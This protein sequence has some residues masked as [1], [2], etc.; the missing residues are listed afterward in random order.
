[1]ERNLLELR[2]I[3]KVFPGVKALDRVNLDLKSGEILG[4]IGENGAGKSTLM[5]IV[6]GSYRKDGG[7]MFYK[8]AEYAPL[9]PADALT[10]G[11]SMIHQEIRLIPSMSVAENIWIGRENKFAKA[12]LINQ[13]K[14]IEETERLL[15][16][17]DVELRADVLVS[18]LSIANMQLVEIVR[19]VSYDADVIIM[20]EP[21]SS[22]TQK[23]IDILYR[24]IRDLAAKGKGVIFI[25][26]KLDELF[27][28]CSRVTVLR[29]GQYVGTE[30]IED[31]TQKQLIQ[32]MVGRE[33][34]DMFPKQ[35]VEIGKVIF[36]AENLCK[37][38]KFSDISFTVREGEIVGFCGLVG[39]GRTEIMEAV[40]GIHPADSGKLYLDD[41][42]IKSRSCKE[43]IRNGI[44]MVTEDRLHSG[45]VHHLSIKSNISMA[46]L[47]SY[48]NLG[49]M[50][51]SILQKDARQMSENMQVKMKDIQQ[52][53][54]TL[55]GGNQ[56]KVILGKWLLTQP[57]LLILD[58][59][60]RGIDVAS[61]AEIYKIIGSLAQNRKGIIVVSSELPELIGICDR[62]IVISHGKITGQLEK[63]DFN[64]EKLMEFAFQVDN[65]EKENGGKAS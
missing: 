8:G 40:F 6:L 59:P 64:Q 44:A 15:K 1:M 65:E 51:D 31:I 9:S 14:M 35:N 24:I 18:N 42:E 41:K 38:R 19:A 3:V 47:D 29:D 36:R 5:K 43:A 45:L 12:G 61:K 25:S 48:C 52:E 33:L 39:A 10:K 27:E 50:K 63:K 34:K 49:F 13:K 4:L 37:A 23:E 17:L 28:V 2:N 32:M 20:D 57:E 58:E 22:L 62:I 53:A 60:T 7:E 16:E 26:H 30:K 11:I 55:S 46:N 54:G 56:Q 21:T